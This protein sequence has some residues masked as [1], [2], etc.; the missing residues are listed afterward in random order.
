MNRITPLKNLNQICMSKKLGIYKQWI[1]KKNSFLPMCDYMQKINYSIQDLNSIIDTIAKFENKNV[2]FII[3]LIDWIKEAFNKIYRSIK[4]ELLVEFIYDKENIL[5]KAKEYFEAIRSFVVAHPLSTTRHLKFGF[6]GNYI[7]VDIRD[8]NHIEII[9]NM[10][11][12]YSID[13]DGL[14]TITNKAYFDFYLLCYSEK[15]DNMKY[16]IKIGCNYSDLYQ[17]AYLYIDKLYKL[18]SYLTKLRKKDF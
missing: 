4:D 12:N 18:N 13:Y 14:H 15:K 16:F 2:V 5:L 17:T 10:N 11:N 9:D 6:D 8:Y 1:Y 7:C 3:V